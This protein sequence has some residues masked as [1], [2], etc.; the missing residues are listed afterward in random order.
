MKLDIDRQTRL[1]NSYA[2]LDGYEA[3]VP[4]VT[5]TKL[6][7]VPFQLGASRRELVKNINA[8]KSSLAAFEQARLALVSETWPDNPPGAGIPENDPKFPAFEAAFKVMV[9]KQDDIELLPLPA[10]VMYGNDFPSGAVALLDELK[11]INED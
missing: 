10:A 4:G 7:R 3:I 5:P 6:V 11:L 1:L 9:A 8:L 2:S